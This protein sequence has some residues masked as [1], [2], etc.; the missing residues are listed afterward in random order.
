M[1]SGDEA[2]VDAIYSLQLEEPDSLSVILKGQMEK[3]W[4]LVSASVTV[5]GKGGTQENRGTAH[6]LH[7]SRVLTARRM[8]GAPG[9]AVS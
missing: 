8:R 3:R 4:P 1:A 2:G 9:G 6:K 5:H 7:G